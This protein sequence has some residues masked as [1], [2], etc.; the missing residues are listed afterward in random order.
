[1]TDIDSVLTTLTEIPEA[2]PDGSCGRSQS[3]VQ[4]V[5]IADIVAGPIAENYSDT[6][7]EKDY[8]F[9]GLDSAVTGDR[10]LDGAVGI[11]ALAWYRSFHWSDATATDN[12][13]IYIPVSSLVYLEER[14]FNG[15][16]IRRDKKLRIAFELLRLHETWHFATDY[17]VSQWEILMGRPCWDILRN[18]VK[19]EGSYFELEEAV[20]NAFMLR[21]LQGAIP[22]IAYKRIEEFTTRQPP[23]YNE[24]V[25]R[26][27]DAA[28]WE[29]VDELAKSY[30]GRTAIESN[31]AILS[32]GLDLSA[33]YP[34]RD[35]DRASNCPLFLVRDEKRINLPS[36][37]VRLIESIDPIVET[38][39]FEKQLKK[40]P[41]KIQESWKSKKVKLK[42]SVPRHPEFEKLKG[43]MKGTYSIRLDLNYRA[44][45]EPAP[46]YSHWEAIAVGTHRDMG[47]D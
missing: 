15:L 29:G 26:V 24:G 22:T 1:M 5:V 8:Y 37:V 4:P 43:E 38:R 10:P 35:L 2:R 34:L 6:N 31:L 23:G 20:A 9:D 39:K 12:W 32:S 11:D 47:H 33:F 36:D 14:L 45:L 28:F 13:G 25:H 27:E 21:E 16:R 17:M 3:K 40:T 19:A 41:L 42:E 30:A 46:D 44:H 18:Q 7:P